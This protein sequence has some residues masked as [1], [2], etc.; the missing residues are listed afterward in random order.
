MDSLL[1]RP[2]DSA[3]AGTLQDVRVDHGGLDVRVTQELLDRPDVVAILEKVRSEGV[4]EG[5]TTCVLVDAH[6]PN[7]LLYCS[8]HRRLV[9]MMAPFSPASG[10]SGRPR[11]GEEVLPREFMRRA[12][13]LSLEGVGHPDLT[14]ARGEILSMNSSRQLHLISRSGC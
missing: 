8:L 2:A 9:E 14:A 3:T 13:I 10:I 11:R 7:G 1:W 5:V 4:P 12:P 6:L